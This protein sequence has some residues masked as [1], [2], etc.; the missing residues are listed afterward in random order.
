MSEFVHLH[1]HTQYSLLDG[2][3][4]ISGMMDKAA[5][6][7]QK[8]VALT[9]HGNMF[10][11]FKFVAEATKRNIKPIIGCEFYLVDD[12]HKKAFSRAK[13]EKDKRYHQLLLAK[14]RTG[15]ENLCKLCSLG[16]MEGLYSKYPRIDKELLV[17]YSEGLIATS[18]C[19]GAELPQTILR[20]K[21]D[22]AEELLKWWLDLF[23]EDYYIEFQRHGGL[24]NID[25]LGVSQEDINQTLL[26][27]AKKY[28]VKTIA[29]NDSHYVEEE[30]WAPHDILLC[31][32]T[33]SSVASEKRFKFPSSDFYF[34]TQ[35]QMKVLFKDIPEAVDNTMEIYDKVETLEL[36]RDVL[37]PNFPIPEGYTTQDDFLR[38]LTYQGAKK[39]YGD[40]TPA[41]KE[42]LDFELSVIKASGYPGY[43]LIV[44]DFTTTA[45]EMGVSVGPGRGSAA[46]SAVAY[47]IGITNVDPIK[48]DLLFERFLNPERISMPDI[49]IDFDDVG[50]QKVIDYV[51][52]KYG[53]NQVA[54]IITYGTM[55][56]KSSI[57]DVGRVLDVPLSEVD[58]VAK[59]FP[60]QLGATLKGVLE[61]GDINKKLKG[62]MNS[63]DVE[64][65]YQFR[66]LAEQPDHIGKML[67]TARKLE[68]SIRN[69]G[70]HACGVVIT[71]DEITKYIPV[72]VAKD[73]DMLVSQFDNSVAE[74]AGLLKMDFL[75]LKTLTIIKDAIAMIKENKDLDI[76][77]DEIP[78]EDELTYKLF[79]RG[80]TIGVFQYESSGMQKYLRDLV[81]TKFEDLIAMNALYRPGPLA[82][83]P[84]F[85]LRK[86]GKEPIKYDLADMKEYLEET[87][88][89]TVYQEQVMLLSQKLADFTK[90]EADML[91]KAMGKKKKKLID[92]MWPKFLEGCKKNGHD[93]TIVKKVWTDWEA[94]ASYAF[95][96]SHS[97]CYALVAFQTAYLKAHHPAEF[98]AS[99]LTHNKN[100]I[101]KLTFFLRECK[102]MGIDVLSPDV[103]ESAADFSVNKKGQIR[104]GLT[105]LKGVGS[106]PVSAVLE[107]RATGVPFKDVFDMMR[108]LDLSSFNKRC[109]DSLVLGG[110]LDCFDMARW[111]YYAP[112]EKYDTFIEHLL[113][114]GNAYQA[115]KAQSLN[116]LFGDSEDILSPEPKIPQAREWSLI[117]KLTKE[118]EVTG[119]YISG[120]PLDDYKLEI[121]NYTTCTL[122]DLENHKGGNLNLAGVVIAAN[123]R[124][125][126]KGN[127]YGFF[128]I[129]DYNSSLEL[130]LWRDDY[131]DYAAR[132]KPGE[133]VFIKGK[134]EYN[135]YR[136][137]YQFKVQEIQQ[138]AAIGL[139]MTESITLKLHVQKITDD[140]IDEI[141]DIC[142][143]SKG[144][145]PLKIEV[146]EPDNQIKLRFRSV[147][148]KVNVDGE[149][150]AKLER[151][152]VKYK[153]NA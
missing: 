116:S 36:A 3:S 143:H 139:K 110:G 35:D 85:V 126:K 132:M 102:R 118:K 6:D 38:G 144:K 78:L 98:M 40:I 60:L 151:I 50:R 117:E 56:A 45:R 31:I 70:I 11:A 148:R 140:L 90:G 134:Y 17:K 106:G 15:Y 114:Y 54:Q 133:V 65:A 119:I 131:N 59:T 33:A 142:K 25:G 29:T 53:R 105:A 84:S 55:A 122:E 48:Y 124:I 69:T 127:G 41:I 138:L 135:N 71:P 123:N 51:I 26:R 100:D 149:M 34:K 129:Q 86:H 83:I 37:L 67:Q 32:N 104:F 18:C 62:K 92:E 147:S 115:Q 99:V 61:D 125:D 72:T 10:G 153:L 21:E 58:R 14:N 52:D 91:R 77:P 16:Y 66:K 1:C 44:Q 150:I 49:D 103:N 80:D 2:A 81:P 47:C 107:Q 42:R 75:G 97:T 87:Y 5:A 145:L 120:H 22:E 111:V 20:G 108:R 76:D 146:I 128:T 74:D 137:E 64:K 28:N 89:I 130:A 63:E 23:G 112:S 113:R 12:R 101:S 19:I 9:D 109:L 30:D 4:S 141:E 39:R 8:A 94:F 73:S 96:K 13:G 7:G 68:G 82:Y 95:N 152:G 57:R 27:L 93:E 43:F 46:G 88:G 79:Q 24:E 121:E 136:E